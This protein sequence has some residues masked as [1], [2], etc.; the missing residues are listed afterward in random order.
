MKIFFIVNDSGYAFVLTNLGKL[1]VD[2][3]VAGLMVKLEMANRH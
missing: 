3:I 2:I 1:I